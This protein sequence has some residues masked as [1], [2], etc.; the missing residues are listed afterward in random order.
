MTIET[1]NEM[2]K[3]VCA[4]PSLESELK[5]AWPKVA[6]VF[7]TTGETGEYS[8]MLKNYEEGKCDYI[9]DSESDLLSVLDV[10][11]EYCKSGITLTDSLILEIVS[12]I[13]FYLQD[14]LN[15]SPTYFLCLP[16][17]T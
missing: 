5:V 12:P 7:N 1:V 10:L 4:H 2:G 17:H 13:Q 6:F 3:R 11:D 8:E 14:H 15:L 9:A 16:I